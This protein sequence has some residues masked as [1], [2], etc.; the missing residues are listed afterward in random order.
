MALMITMT[1]V[2][3]QRITLDRKLW[4][5]SDHSE[6]VEDGDPRAA[7]LLGSKGKQIS[8]A[9]A[10]RLG[11][12]VGEIEAEVAPGFVLPGEYADLEEWNVADL[13]AELD[14]RELP[15][16]GNKKALVKRLKAA[17]LDKMQAPEIGGDKGV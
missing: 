1:G 13:R 16:A 17:L 15:T 6:V 11:L 7:F 4:Y 9:E 5:T 3:G 8:Q 10:E 2:P 14:E 12:V